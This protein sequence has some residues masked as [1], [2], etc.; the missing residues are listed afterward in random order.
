MSA[1]TA[2][3]I[4]MRDIITVLGTSGGLAITAWLLVKNGVDFPAAC[5]DQA[6]NEGKRP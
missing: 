1:Y 4:W 2:G 3:V 6:E 5:P